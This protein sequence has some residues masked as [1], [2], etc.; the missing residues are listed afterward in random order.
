MRGLAWKGIVAAAAVLLSAAS[1]PARAD[2]TVTDLALLAYRVFAARIVTPAQVPELVRLLSLLDVPV[3]ST[4]ADYAVLREDTGWRA[5]YPAVLAAQAG[6]A[7]R[8]YRAAEARP[9]RDR[10]ALAGQ[11][12]YATLLFVATDAG[13]A[14]TMAGADADY[15]RFA[16]DVVRD[17]EPVCTHVPAPG[18][19]PRDHTVTHTCTAA[20]GNAVIRYEVVRGGVLISG[21]PGGHAAEAAR[22]SAW[23]VASETL[24]WRL[25]GCVSA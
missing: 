19:T 2:A 11:G 12:L 9:D 10:I 6:D 17:L 4:M 15:V 21:P 25:R 18:N 24:A 22:D 16:Q 14:G 13:L 23:L 3:A 7:V 20:D 1:P 8:R 5:S